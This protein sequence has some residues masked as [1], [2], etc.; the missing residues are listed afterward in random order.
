MIE[1]LCESFH[2]ILLGFSV[3]S[4]YKLQYKQ[5]E[6]VSNED[7]HDIIVSEIREMT[8]C[9]RQYS[10]RICV[11]ENFRGPEVSAIW[12]WYHS[13][14]AHQHRKGH[15]V[16]KTGDNDC[17]VN[18]SRYSLSTALCESNSLSGQV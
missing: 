1:R 5:M 6:H 4:R 13:L 17:N 9:V 10:A 12:W 7:F 16:P 18:S 11:Y 8:E 14:T 2:T 3:L 15:T